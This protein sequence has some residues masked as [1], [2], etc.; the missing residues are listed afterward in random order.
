MIISIDYDDTW[1]ADPGLWSRFARQAARR[2]H[3]VILVTNRIG[4]P[5]DARELGRYAGRFV[6][7][8]IFAGL[9]PKRAAAVGAGYDV[10]VWIDDLPETVAGG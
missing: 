4:T 1:S 3:T 2:G 9:G 10:D 5:M 6:E 7:Q 8:V